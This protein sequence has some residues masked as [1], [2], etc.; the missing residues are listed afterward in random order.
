[1]SDQESTL[2]KG[3][4]LKPP[5]TGAPTWIKGQIGIKVSDA[6]EYLK[7]NEND[8]GYVNL[9]L[10]ESKGGKMYLDLNNYVARDVDSAPP[11]DDGM[12]DPF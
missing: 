5:H 7:A 9:D 4:F 11:P 6:I 1:M 8:R 10:K 2:P 12:E 3:F